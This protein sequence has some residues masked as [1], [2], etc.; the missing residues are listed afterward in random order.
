MAENIKSKIQEENLIQVQDL[1]KMA[2]KRWRWFA[3]SLFLSLGIAVLYIAKSIPVYM[4]SASLL[5]KEDGKSINSD[6]S[7]FSTLDLFR[8]NTNINNEILTLQSPALMA[9][10]VKKRSLNVNYSTRSGIRQKTLY[11]Q[12]PISVVFS[13]TKED[14]PVSFS[15]ELLKNKVQLSDI[16]I[17]GEVTN[18]PV[19]LCELSKPIK[20]PFGEIMILPTN[21]YH[22]QPPNTIIRVDKSLLAPIVSKYSSALKVELGNSDAS[23]VKLSITDVSV[24]RAEDILNTLIATYNENWIED[25]NQIAISTSD[26]IDKRLAVIENELGNVDNNISEFKSKNL[27]PDI[28]AATSMYLA[29]SSS[30][31]STLLSLGNQLSVAQFI[32]SHI[33][34]HAKHQLIPAN[35]GLENLNTESLISDYNTSILRRNGLI[36]NSS[37]KNPLIKDLDESLDVMRQSI[38]TSIDN[39]ISSY[40]LQIANI[41]QSEN[42]TNQQ[43]ASN[44]N[45]AKYL[46]SVE[47]Q[48]K[49][50][51]AL[52]LY[53]LQKREEN[54]LSQA[55]TA[56]NSRIINPPSGSSVPVSPQKPKII[57]VAIAIGLIIPT[58][59]IFILH[60]LDITVRGQKDLRNLT[61]PFIGEIPLN[62]DISGRNQVWRKPSFVKQKNRHNL[63]IV[64]EAK[65]RNHINEAFRVIRTNLDFIKGGT[66]QI[67]TIMLTSFN[68]NSGKTFITT[69]L[70]ISH[71]LTGS[72]VIVVDLDMRKS[73]LSRNFKNTDVGVSDY[74]GGFIDD[75]DKII[76]KN[77]SQSILDVIPVGTIPPNPTELL[78]SERLP[79]LLAYLKDKYDYI[80]IDCP[81][82]DI[83]ADTSIIEK[84]VDFTIFV[85]RAG[86]L[87]RRMLPELESMYQK[88]RFKNMAMILNGSTQTHN[89]YGYYYDKY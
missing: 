43:I 64:V 12:S 7:T 77:V 25:K 10:V 38:L 4:S 18:F 42:Q 21:F 55:F 72:K 39:L 28:Q 86:L 20:T 53:L 41:K 83:V 85:I 36:N 84:Q 63:N 89:K 23:I 71:A 62:I 58:V 67:K 33:R 27:L 59:L 24:S 61:L 45:Q 8:T 66:N 48:Q 68:S 5:I 57:L 30:N 26:F 50:K 3:L 78:L 29:Q 88:K 76:I 65:N 51:E 6:I 75:P 15:I 74:L 56:Y 32:K 34:D 70:G 73:D 11:S 1:W 69:N 79:A 80:L 60:S 35:L 2:V 16:L 9:E 49:V 31:S 40:K 13:S 37:E 82:I 81:P 47:R 54:Q 44:P 17:Q 19:T 87:D 22:Q 14:K 46:L 52:Y